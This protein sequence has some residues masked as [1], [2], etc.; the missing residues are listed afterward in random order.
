[1]VFYNLASSVVFFGVGEGELVIDDGSF[2]DLWLDV[3]DV[4]CCRCSGCRRCLPDFQSSRGQEIAM[5][6]EQL[7]LRNQ[8]IQQQRQELSDEKVPGDLAEGTRVT[9]MDLPEKLPRIWIHL[10]R[11]QKASRWHFTLMT[12]MFTAAQ[13][14]SFCWEVP[15][16][17]LRP[18]NSAAPCG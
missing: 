18:C 3:L 9:I 6:R 16:Q 11:I 7:R 5:L 2:F 8:H 12:L 1:M 17:S 14:M 4:E 10:E 13:D 15:W